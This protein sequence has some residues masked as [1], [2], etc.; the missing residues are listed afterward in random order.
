ME[1]EMEYRGLFASAGAYSSTKAESGTKSENK[2]MS[3]SVQVLGGHQHIATAVT[4]FYAPTFK[5][6]LVVSTSL[7]NCL[8]LIVSF[9]GC[10]SLIIYV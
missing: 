3:T 6:T 5:S 1:A 2:F 10:Y 4:D 8:L 7:N 9:Y